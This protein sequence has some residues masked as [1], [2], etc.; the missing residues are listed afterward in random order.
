MANKT[1]YVRDEELWMWSKKYA[2]NADISISRLIENL[3]VRHQKERAFS[4]IPDGDHTN[5]LIDLR[6]RPTGIKDE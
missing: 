2:D 6:D 5:P 4:T 1:I 3:L